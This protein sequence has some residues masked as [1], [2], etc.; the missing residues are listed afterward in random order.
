MSGKNKK[1]SEKIAELQEDITE[2][3]IVLN[4]TKDL[5]GK[6]GENGGTSGETE[7]V[8]RMPENYLPTNFKRVNSS[9][10]KSWKRRVPLWPNMKIYSS[11]SRQIL[12]TSEN[13]HRRKRRISRNMP[14]LSSFS[15]Y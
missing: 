12:R 2:D 11:E 6:E 3:G 7:F 1:G 9:C 10:R 8:K 13:G 14:M 15:M 4:G 5:S